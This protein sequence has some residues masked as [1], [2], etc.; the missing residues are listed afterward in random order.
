[1]GM[2]AQKRI[3]LGAHSSSE[4]PLN[5]HLFHFKKQK[6][7]HMQCIEKHKI[8]DILRNTSGGPARRTGGRKGGKG[9]EIMSI[10]TPSFVPGA[11]HY[12]LARV[13]GGLYQPL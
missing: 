3:A 1:V 12:V 4:F 11:Q 2:P 13:G 10:V 7:R 5:S 6:K 9:R 8:K